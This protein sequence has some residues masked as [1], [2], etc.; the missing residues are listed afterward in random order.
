MV[1]AK[2]D[3]MDLDDMRKQSE[4][5]QNGRYLFCPE[6]SHLCMWDDQPHFFPGVI[7]FLKDVADGNSK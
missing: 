5:V 6:G 3:T 4:L 1:G 7:S 2:F